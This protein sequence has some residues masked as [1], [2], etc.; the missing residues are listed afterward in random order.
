MLRRTNFSTNMDPTTQR[1]GMTSRFDRMSVS[2]EILM[3]ENTCR[4]S[5]SAAKYVDLNQLKTSPSPQLI[6]TGRFRQ[7]M[8]PRDNGNNVIDDHH[9]NILISMQQDEA[10]N[11]LHQKRNGNYGTTRFEDQGERYLAVA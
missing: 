1:G 2:P 6:F 7:A 11:D 4:H 3:T 9:R 8:T 5:C 10:R